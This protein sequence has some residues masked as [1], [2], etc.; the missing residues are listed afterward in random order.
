MLLDAYDLAGFVDG[1][2]EAP[3]QFIVDAEGR[4]ISNP[5]YLLFIK[6]NK[7]LAFCLISTIS[8]DLL[9]NFTGFVTPRQIWCKASRLFT[10]VFDYKVAR[11]KHDLHSVT[12]GERSVE[13]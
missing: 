5:S 1:S 4:S 11:L 12:K 10:I 13:E 2:V 3:P 9:P 7:L 8:G 6:Q